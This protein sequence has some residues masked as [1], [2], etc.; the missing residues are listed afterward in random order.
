MIII[1]DN[2]IGIKKQNLNKLFTDFT[3]LDEHKKLNVKG[4]GLGL[5]I[6]RNIISK[7]GGEVQVESEEGKGCKFKI[8]L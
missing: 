2:G 5:S 4:T 6:C 1:E 3:K 8:T 7:M